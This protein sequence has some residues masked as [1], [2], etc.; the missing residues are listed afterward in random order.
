MALFLAQKSYRQKQRISHMKCMSTG[1]YECLHSMII[2]HI[3]SNVKTFLHQANNKD[4]KGKTTLEYCPKIRQFWDKCMSGQVKTRSS[5]QSN[6]HFLCEGT[7][8]HLENLFHT[9]ILLF[10]TFVLVFRL[11]GGPKFLKFSVGPFR[12]YHVFASILL[13]VTV[14]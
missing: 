12:K 10:F 8:L 14:I 2:N 6:Q 7:I 5:Y 4:T 11:L 3:N 1:T 9:C 13:F